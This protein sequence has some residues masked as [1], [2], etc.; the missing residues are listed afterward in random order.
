MA[1]TQVG[2]IKH[3]YRYPV[4]GM[5]GEELDTAELSWHGLQGDRRYALAAR[6]DHSG[7]PWLSGRLKAQLISY[8]PVFEKPEE[9]NSSSI[10]VTTP[11][12]ECFPLK[13]GALL[14]ELETLFEKPLELI[15]LNRGCFDSATI[16]LISQ[17]TLDSIGAAVGETL[18]P[19]RFRPNVFMELDD[20][21]SYPEDAWLGKRLQIGEAADAPLVQIDRQNVRCVMI[22]IEP[23]T[24]AK[25][26]EVLKYVTQKREQCAGVYAS[27]VRTGQLV[28]GAPIF[29][30]D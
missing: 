20:Q 22:N 24:V 7:F 27:P 5:R 8:T 3:I 10:E 13:G 23:H 4:K 12:G 11:Q 30:L 19:R 26:P 16:S 18:G 6:G 14:H 21:G 2:R 28:Q 17:N 1:S 25:N 29:L 15:K 9:P